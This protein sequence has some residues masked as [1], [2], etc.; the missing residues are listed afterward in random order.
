[1]SLI[2][3]R[4]QPEPREPVD[5]LTK[6]REVFESHHGGG[7]PP[8]TLEVLVAG[9]RAVLRLPQPWSETDNRIVRYLDTAY[10]NRVHW[11]RTRTWAERCGVTEHELARIAE[12]EA[13]IAARHEEY[14]AA[15]AE[16]VDL[17]R[18]SERGNVSAAEMDRH[19]R[20]RGRAERA[21]ILADEELI[22]AKGELIRYK[23]AIQERYLAS[24][25]AWETIYNS[26]G[27]PLYTGP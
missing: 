27:T 5:P 6:A 14:G 23:L 7:F 9:G 20:A 13:I 3:K 8:Q 12:L 4:E 21:Y 18:A 11:M 26:D 17:A 16:Y 25:R 10:G 1:V 24:S 2:F 22:I 19:L 15:R